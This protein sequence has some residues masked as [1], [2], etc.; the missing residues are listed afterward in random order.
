MSRTDT[1]PNLRDRIPYAL[2]GR[3]VEFGRE[4]EDCENY[5]EP[6]MRARIAAID[7][8]HDVFVVTFDFTEFAEHNRPLEQANYYDKNGVACL[9]ARQAGYYADLDTYYLP[10]PEIWQPG[11]FRVIEDEGRLA[12]LEAYALEMR[13]SGAA[14]E[15]AG[16]ESPTRISY[17]VWLENRL[18]ALRAAAE[19]E[20]KA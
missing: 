6:G 16:A 1:A 14:T 2:F 7:I 8:E 15:D 5:G 19:S 4:I 17:T 12:L 9:T 20:P 11:Y 18:I 13:A 10:E 3:V